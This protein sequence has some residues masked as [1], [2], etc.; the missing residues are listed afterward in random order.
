MRKYFSRYNELANGVLRS[1]SL[2][3]PEIDLSSLRVPPLAPRR[4]VTPPTAGRPPQ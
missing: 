2:D 4:V 3:M 1:L